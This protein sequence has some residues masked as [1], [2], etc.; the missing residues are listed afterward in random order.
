MAEDIVKNQETKGEEKKN[1][2]KKVLLDVHQICNECR[3]SGHYSHFIQKKYKGKS[4]DLNE[5]KDLLKKDG[6]DY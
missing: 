3:I 5:W 6:L 4:Y 2:T 1:K